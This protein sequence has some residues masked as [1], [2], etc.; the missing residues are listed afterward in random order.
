MSQARVSDVVYV[1]LAL[2]AAATAIANPVVSTLSV[3]LA[4]I[5]AWASKLE[6]MTTWL[7]G[8]SAITSVIGSGLAFSYVDG[9]THYALIG[10]YLTTLASLLLAYSVITYFGGKPELRLYILGA[11][12]VLASL[13]LVPY[14]LPP[15]DVASMASPGIAAVIAYSPALAVAAAGNAFTA[16]SVASTARPRPR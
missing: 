16:L 8:A 11:S 14:S 10:S 5:V 15:R 4:A 1:F 12:L 3:V 7:A 9:G 2:A 13:V 6:G